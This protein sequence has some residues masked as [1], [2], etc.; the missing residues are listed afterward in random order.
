MIRSIIVDDEYLQ[1]EGLKNLL[2]RY[3]PDVEVVANADSVSSAREAIL[4]H[5]PDLVFLDI[6]LTDGTGFDLLLQLDRI[7]FH[8]IFVTVHE[9]K[10]LAAF[11][12]SAT[13]Y[14]VKPVNIQD[15][16]VAVNK[17]RENLK[18]KDEALNIK[19]LLTFITE[20]NKQF[21]IVNIPS[22]DGFKVIQLSEIITCEADGFCTIFYLKGN[23]RVVSS[24]NLKYYEDMIS[25]KGFMR[26]HHSFMI[27]L[28]HVREYSREGVI[29]LS[30]GKQS[31]LGNAYK[32]EFLNKYD[33][34][35]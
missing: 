20:G 19:T 7:D 35:K 9:E 3:C 28:K 26:V 17:V 24:K 31:P 25:S 5:S 10:A 21:D 34:Y 16:K 8:I 22:T 14:L 12:F 11:R 29:L 13:D 30:D 23:Q 6:G 33:R 2:T 18:M 27:N 15:L 1:R 4:M 32:K